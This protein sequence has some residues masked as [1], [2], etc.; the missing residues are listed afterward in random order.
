MEP[1][2]D[3]D[4]LLNI[5]ECIGR[6]AVTEAEAAANRARGRG[7]RKPRPPIRGEVPMAPSTWW[8]GI[9]N[10]SFPAPVKIG[11]RKCMWRRSEVRAIATR[12]SR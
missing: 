5:A 8:A 3:S 7:P 9:K 11:T 2:E 6:K 10:G 12:E 4:P 1:F